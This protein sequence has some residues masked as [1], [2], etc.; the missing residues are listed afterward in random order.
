MKNFLI[1]SLVTWFTVG[2]STEEVPVVYTPKDVGPI[3]RVSEP[4]SSSYRPAYTIDTL[5]Y[6]GYI[7]D[8]AVT[9]QFIIRNTNRQIDFQD[10]VQG[11]Y[12]YDAYNN[13]IELTGFY[14]CLDWCNIRL[15]ESVNGEP[16]GKWDL[17]ADNLAESIKGTWKDP[18]TGKESP[19]VLKN[20][21]ST[22]YL[23]PK[24]KKI[25][26]SEEASDLFFKRHI[27][28]QQ[29]MRYKRFY[30]LANATKEENGNSYNY[31]KQYNFPLPVGL[32]L[33]FENAGTYSDGPITIAKDWR[34]QGDGFDV[35]YDSLFPKRTEID[36]EITTF[37]FEHVEPTVIY[38]AKYDMNAFRLNMDAIEKLGYHLV[39]EISLCNT[40]L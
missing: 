24:A 38:S 10:S 37:I 11:V 36:Y 22:V 18:K 34:I 25:F 39:D 23:H 3:S 40:Y 20:I 19:I 30:L 33:S 12:R 15:T 27:V 26:E 5:N 13:D 32:R 9:A 31:D 28:H 6:K 4:T 7:G 17:E 14:G 1:L 21:E 2:C 29:D 35:A 16:T 8:A